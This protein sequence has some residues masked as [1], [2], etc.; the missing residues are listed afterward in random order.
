MSLEQTTA[1]RRRIVCNTFSFSVVVFS[2]INSGTGLQPNKA[3]YNYQQFETLAVIL[4]SCPVPMVAGKN[5]ATVYQQI[6]ML[7]ANII[8]EHLASGEPVNCP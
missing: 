8:A 3:S 2:K 4:A 6:Q 5:N 1:D 7:H